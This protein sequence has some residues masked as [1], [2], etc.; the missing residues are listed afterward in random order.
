LRALTFHGRRKIH[1]ESVDDPAL[2]APTDVIVRVELTAICGSDL[3]V[4]HEREKGLDHGTVMGHEFVGEIVET[5]SEV[6][7]IVP[8]VA[9]LSPFTTSCGNCYY[10]REGLTARCGRGQL[11]GWVQQGRGLQGA[12]AEYVRVPLAESTLLSIPD[13]VEAEEALLLGD[14]LTTGYF[15]A[16]RAGIRPDGVYAVLGCG[17]V[18][19]SAIVGVRE[20]GANNIVAIDSVAERLAL[21]ARFGATPIDYRSTDAVAAVREMTEGRGADGVLE[22][23]GSA[24]AHRLAIDL[25]RPGATVSVVGVH[26]DEQFG[27]SPAEAYDKN[28]TYRVGRCPARHLLRE[29][30]PV[31]QK[32]AYDLTS[33]FSHR[34]PLEQGVEGYRI[35]DEKRDGCTKVV[36]RPN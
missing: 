9:V 2:E 5:G 36:L 31:V 15:A 1:H 19:L 6:S 27:F 4:Y 10:C 34:L 29:V 11:F 18:G 30:V 20:H 28:L 25:A 7:G 32:K 12:Q 33:M 8:G 17:P 13:G 22:V 26:N 24:E 21:A 3:H 16:S 14:V 35:F 23:V